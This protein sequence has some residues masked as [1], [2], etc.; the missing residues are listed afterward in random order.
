[1]TS[2]KASGPRPWVQGTVAA[3]CRAQRP[4]RCGHLGCPRHSAA[5]SAP[6]AYSSCS[7]CVYK[8][9]VRQGAPNSA[10]RGRPGK[11]SP[12]ATNR[13]ASTASTFC[14]LASCRLGRQLGGH[15]LGKGLMG[16]PYPG[17]YTLSTPW[18]VLPHART[19][20]NI[21][22]PS[23]HFILGMGKRRQN[24]MGRP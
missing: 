23:T 5:P 20:S 10:A 15:G 19:L 4:L 11:C 14:I 22:A 18:Q 9:I 17:S 1:M 13:R 7:Y 8:R 16:P 12:E 3:L 21:K 6:A 2:I 24:P